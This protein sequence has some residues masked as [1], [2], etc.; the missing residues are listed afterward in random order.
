[1]EGCPSPNI[2]RVAVDLPENSS[3]IRD[4]EDDDEEMLSSSR[5]DRIP[6]IRRTIPL[7]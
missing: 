4:N 5:E 1:M 2:V 3:I 6:L 7:Q